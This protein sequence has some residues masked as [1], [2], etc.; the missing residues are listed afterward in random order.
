M[1]VLPVD[2]QNSEISC[3]FE[4]SSSVDEH[5]KDRIVQGSDVQYCKVLDRIKIG[6]I[7]G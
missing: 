3:T 7:K 2:G 4:A 1:C 5:T 6:R